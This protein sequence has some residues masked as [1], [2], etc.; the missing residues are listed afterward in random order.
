MRG[1][2]QGDVGVD[3]DVKESVVG[4]GSGGVVATTTVRG[5]CVAVKGDCVT[6]KRD[7]VNS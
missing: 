7:C 5:D 4:T 6:V 2:G 3:H 1:C